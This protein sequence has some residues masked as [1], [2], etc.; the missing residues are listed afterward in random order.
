MIKHTMLV[1]RSHIKVT[2]I[3]M[4]LFNPDDKNLMQLHKMVKAISNKMKS[5]QYPI[6][7]SLTCAIRCCPS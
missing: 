5:N 1:Q 4:D 7:R 6:R 2:H 3:K